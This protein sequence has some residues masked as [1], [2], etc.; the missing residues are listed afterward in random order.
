M[1]EFP[2]E[3]R[4]SPSLL[5]MPGPEDWPRNKSS[6]RIAGAT[7]PAPLSDL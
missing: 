3:L 7:V 4:D 5:P 1:Y 2:A 6:E